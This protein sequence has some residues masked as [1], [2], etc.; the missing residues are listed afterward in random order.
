MPKFK[1]QKCIY[2][3]K[4]FPRLTKDHV[5]PA[6]W[7]PSSTPENLEKWSVPSCTRCN[8]RLGAIEEDLFTRLALCIDEKKRGAFGIQEKMVKR[9]FP[10]ILGSQ[11]QLKRNRNELLK[12]INDF[13]VCTGPGEDVQNPSLHR[14]GNKPGTKIRIPRLN[15]ISFSK[16]V[17]AGLEFK[18]RN[19]LI[20]VGKKITI[21]RSIQTVEW[22]VTRKK[23]ELLLNSTEVR[24]EHSPG[25]I[26]RYGVDPKNDDHIIY[27]VKIWD[28]FEIWARIFPS[29]MLRK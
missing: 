13:K 27:N 7:F 17:V 1:N 10:T 11:E 22:E 3:L 8:N 29:K 20:D 14:H 5:L 25:F 28:H 4:F 21:Y 23:L 9:I 18:L 2:C 26:I 12:I 15:L 24:V 6:S 16:K 19:K